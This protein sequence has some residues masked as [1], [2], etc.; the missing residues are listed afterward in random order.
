MMIK[1]LKLEY[2]EGSKFLIRQDVSSKDKAH[3]GVKARMQAK[4]LSLPEMEQR[5]HALDWSRTGGGMVQK[6]II[7]MTEEEYLQIE[8]VKE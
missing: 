1:V 3:Q 8:K 4:F 2:W 5:R 7:Y 6:T